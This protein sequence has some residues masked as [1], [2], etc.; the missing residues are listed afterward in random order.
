MPKVEKSN[1]MLLTNPVSQPFI[2]P[3]FSVGV[4]VCL[5]YNYFKSIIADNTIW[6]G[7]THRHIL[8]N[9]TAIKTVV[10]NFVLLQ[11][12]LADRVATTY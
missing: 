3:T 10:A 12:A 4:F 2:T 5:L 9:K 11:N 7:T 1:S 8:C 6:R